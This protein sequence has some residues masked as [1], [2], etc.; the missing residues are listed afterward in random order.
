MTEHVLY[1]VVNLIDTYTN[2]YELHMH[3]SNIGVKRR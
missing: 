3:E 2:A 1:T